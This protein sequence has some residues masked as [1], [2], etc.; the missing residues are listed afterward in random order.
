MEARKVWQ[1]LWTRE[2]KNAVFDFICGALSGI[3]LAIIVVDALL[4]G[5]WG[6]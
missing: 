4:G 5:N 3:I 6:G 2:A 1:F